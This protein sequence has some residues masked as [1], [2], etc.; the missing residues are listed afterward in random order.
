MI[1]SHVDCFNCTWMVVNFFWIIFT[2]RSI[3]FGVMGRVRDCS[4]NKFITCVVN[5]WQ[6]V[7]YFSSSLWYRF[8]IWFS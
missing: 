3:S 8:R 4:R 7:S 2:I 6:D 1:A 5:S